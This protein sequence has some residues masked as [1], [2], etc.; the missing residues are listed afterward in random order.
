MTQ[1]HFT[2]G[3]NFTLLV[4]DAR[5]E[6]PI[7]TVVIAHGM[8]EHGAR[9]QRLAAALNTKG[10]HVIVP[11]LRGHGATSRLNGVRG[12]FGKTGRNRVIADLEE[13]IAEV[14]TEH[15]SKHP[16]VLFGHSMGS[17][18]AMRVAQ[19]QKTQ[20]SGLVLS[21]FPVHPGLLVGAGKL[22]G[23]VL[24]ALFGSDKPSPFMDK[25]TFGKFTKGIKNRRTDFDWLSRNPSE[26]DAYIADPDCG[27]VFTNGFFG[28]LARLTDE[29]HTHLNKLDPQLPVLYFAGDDD[30]VVGKAKGFARNVAKMKSAI[31]LLEQRLY[32]GG[33]HELLND[34]CRDE[35]MVDLIQFINKCL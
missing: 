13:L 17:M 18:L 8:A 21:A 1:R 27:E 2:S 10:I 29:A 24:S 6:T 31:P 28:E 3:D 35:V 19:R 7:A 26:V 33:R 30:P 12:S 34:V 22:V 32:V 9:Y 11:D 16:V 25:L 14:H 23:N 5:I 15:G 4:H 20:L